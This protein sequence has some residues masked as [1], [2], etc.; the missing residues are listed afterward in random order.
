M[1]WLLIG[2]SSVAAQDDTFRQ[3]I[4][5]MRIANAAEIKIVFLKIMGST[6][7]R[8]WTLYDEYRA[9][10]NKIDDEM[11][12]LI[13]D[14]ADVYNAGSVKDEQ[15]VELLDRWFVIKE[16]YLKLKR[17]YRKKLKGV[18]T[19]VQIGRFFQIDNKAELAEHFQL[20]SE[21]PLMN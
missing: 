14:Y 3:Q 20:S 11:Y 5:Q 6:D 10:K 18:I 17:K 13:F 15:A 9:A 7:E 8:F 4:D 12:Q 21:V 19:E 16:D 2:S 1:L